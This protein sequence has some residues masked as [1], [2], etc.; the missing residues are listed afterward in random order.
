MTPI[1]PWW[2]K[3]FAKLLLARLPVPY[4]FWRKLN[5][6]RHGEMN[7]PERA[8]RT[9]ENFYRR[10][11]ENSVI[12]Q[13]FTMLELGP[14]D[15]ILSGLV[16]RSM[17]ASQAWLVD[18]GAFADTDVAA[19]HR[20]LALLEQRGHVALGLSDV[21]SVDNMLKR[22]NV[23]YLTRGTASL[24]DIPDASV[25]L[26]W[27]QVVLEH[28]PHDEFP[29]FLRQLR[30]IVKPQGIGVHSVDFRDHLGNALNNLRFSRD[31]WEGRTFRHSGFYTNR[32]RPGTMRALFE[33]AGFDVEVVSETYWPEIPTPRSAMA[34]PFRDLPDA[35]L[36]LAEYEVLL[37]PR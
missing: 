16:A 10:A 36:R 18:A 5:L 19:C 34:E 9:F 28:V 14:G 21:T 20:T 8:I 7:D 22:A 11:R 12:P 25:D 33:D 3:L 1:F 26:F 37:R 27:S 29:E 15:S 2:A 30:R 35:E 32:I 13:N 24:C 6:F 17:G 4:S 23:T 31:T